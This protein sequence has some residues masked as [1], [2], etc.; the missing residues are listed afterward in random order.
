MGKAIIS[1]QLSADASIGPSI[2]WYEPNGEHETAAEDEL[3]L[4]DAM[5]LGRKTYE[6]LAPIWMSSTGRFADRVN[7]LPKY[8]AA[9]SLAEPLDWNATLIKGDLVEQVRQFKTRHDGNLLTYG[10]GE[11]A[12]ALV[13]HGLVD[14]VQFWVHPVVWNEQARPFHGLGRIRM[15]LKDC[16]VFRNG[17]VRHTYEPVS[18]DT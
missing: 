7:S 17:V 2:G 6:A 18:V 8:V 3:N 5:L 11:F 9:T 1:V 12:F 16:T 15:N 10:C 13:Q 4:A 14:E